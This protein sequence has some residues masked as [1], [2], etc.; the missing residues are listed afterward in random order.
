MARIELNGIVIDARIRARVWSN[1]AKPISQ[2]RNEL[3]R[4]YNIA[5]KFVDG[6]SAL[7][8]G[9]KS[10]LMFTLRD[11]N[12]GKDALPFELPTRLDSELAAALAIA[13][14]W[15][16]RLAC[17]IEE[18]CQWETPPRASS[19]PRLVIDQLDKLLLR[20]TGNGLARASITKGNR[21]TRAELSKEFV[22]RVLELSGSS[23]TDGAVDD[24]MKD[25]I[26]RRRSSGV[27][28]K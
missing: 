22:R 6:I 8:S 20:H 10:A 25:V 27:K 28:A 9:E 7:R 18:T 12:Y 16:S 26:A 3:K 2:V 17:A 19:L 24:A 14:K 1:S 23:L 21:K 11:E 13:R 15:Q 4:L 5:T